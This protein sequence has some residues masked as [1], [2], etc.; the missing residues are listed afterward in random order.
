MSRL[1]MQTANWLINGG[2][3][4]LTLWPQLNTKIPVK[5]ESEPAEMA[6]ILWL[7]DRNTGKWSATIYFGDLSEKEFDDE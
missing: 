2:R 6:E 4:P 5:D 7:S 3:S 1:E